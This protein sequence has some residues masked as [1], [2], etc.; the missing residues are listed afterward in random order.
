MS[1]WR[2]TCLIR[3][4]VANESDRIGDHVLRTETNVSNTED[5][6]SDEWQLSITDTH[7]THQLL[8]VHQM[9]MKRFVPL[10]D[11]GDIWKPSQH[12]NTGP[13]VQAFVTGSG[14]LPLHNMK[15][16]T[17]YYY[18]LITNFQLK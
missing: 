1:D 2:V 11:E 14:P 7:N 16:K 3:L 18:N 8:K 6:T 12:Y 10:V 17:L 15:Y 4:T 5:L 9:I 13:A